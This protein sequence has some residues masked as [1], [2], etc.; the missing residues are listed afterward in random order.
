MDIASPK[1]TTA[2]YR[3]AV[4]PREV[5]R[6]FA[7]DDGE[8]LDIL[9]GAWAACFYGLFIGLCLGIVPGWLFAAGGTAAFIR[10]FNALHE[11]FHAR[12]RQDRAWLGRHL[13][14]VT[15]PWMLGY[16]ALRDNHLQHHTWAGQAG[17]DPDHYLASGPWFVA[18]WGA[19]TQP[20]QALPRYRAR[21]GVTAKVLL[22]VGLHAMSFAAI[23]IVGWGWPLVWWIAVTRVANTAS[24]FIF[25]WC[26]HH[27][28]RWGDDG[29]PA[30]PA[31]LRTVWA[32][33]LSRDNLLGVEYHHVHHQYP[34]VRGCDLPELSKQLSRPPSEELQR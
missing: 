32:A 20:E 27:P 3:Y 22:P 2:S 18:L 14:V 21:R 9:A 31:A 10:N 7:A 34:F 11:G 23:V 15:G 13:L 33:L 24:W 17:R 6:R 4:P 19:L 16:T 29:P 5:A 28:A 12:R 30:L 1:P 25:D 8:R 26:L